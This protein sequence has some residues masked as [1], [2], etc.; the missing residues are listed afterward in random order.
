M[1]SYVI[2]HHCKKL[3]KEADA[4]L[5]SYTD[6]LLG[7]G[8]HNICRWC[9]EAALPTPVSAGEVPVARPLSAEDMGP[10]S[11][12]EE[13]ESS[14]PPPGALWPQGYEYLKGVDRRLAALEKTWV[15]HRGDHLAVVRSEKEPAASGMAHGELG[16]RI[17]ASSTTPTQEAPSDAEP[18]Q[19]PPECCLPM[20]NPHYNWCRRCWTV[21]ALAPD[22][23]Q[24]CTE[25]ATPSSSQS[26]QPTTTFRAV[27]SCMCAKDEK[28]ARTYLGL[29]PLR[30]GQV[31]KCSICGAWWVYE[32][33]PAPDVPASPS[34]ST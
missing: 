17:M 13:T 20:P 27:P 6:P 32:L 28:Q 34:E 30:T 10:S 1:E 33:I 25:A 2:C 16:R 8:I 18:C 26:D 21:F 4:P 5:A 24:E 22:S 15:D 23:P 7:H 9:T 19:H 12:G 11:A 3:R 14:P 29:D 31:A